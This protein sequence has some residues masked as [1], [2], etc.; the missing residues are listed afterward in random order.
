MKQKMLLFICFIAFNFTTTYAQING[1][2]ASKINAFNH[3]PIG[4]GTAE[5]EPNIGITR[6][7]KYWDENG[8][9]RDAFQSSDSFQIES[10]VSFRMAYPLSTKLEIGTFIANDFSNWSLKYALGGNDTFGYGI[11]GGLNLPYGIASIDKTNRKSEDIST[12]GLGIIASYTINETTSVDANLQYQGY[13]YSAPDLP[14]SDIFFSVDYGHYVGD[15]DIQ[16]MSSFVYG[17]SI[18]EENG[19]YVLSFFPGIAIETN[20]NYVLFFSGAFDILGKNAS[21]TSGFAAAWTL[22]L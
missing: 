4:V 22:L 17:K 15:T 5:F 11:M 12:Y 20:P 2:S 1:V 6:F 19:G 18:G 14:D 9:L 10:V 16:L 8:E 7:S 13:I 21:K 3:M